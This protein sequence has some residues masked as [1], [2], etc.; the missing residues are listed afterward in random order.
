MKILIVSDVVDP[1]IY[2]L[3]LKERHGD[4]D[5]ILSCGD[6]PFD[7]LDFLVSHLGKPLYYV[8]GNHDKIIPGKNNFEACALAGENNIDKKIINFKN[9]LIGGFS[10]CMNYNNGHNQFTEKQIQ[11]KIM[12]TMPQLHY[13][14]L[15]YK[16]YID[17]LITH[18]PP[19]GINDADDRCHTGFK[20]FLTY[21]DKYRPSYMLHGHVHVYASNLKRE[22]K[23]NNTIVV[24]AYGHYILEI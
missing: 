1:V 24:N 6:L 13:N 15:K 21:L 5:C 14:K 19:L 22:F 7:Y 18:A 12:R 11:R 23:Y 3:T 4:V 8:L 2:N 20:A 10:G 17:I 9:T 16:K